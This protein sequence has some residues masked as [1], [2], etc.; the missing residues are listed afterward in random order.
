MANKTYRYLSP[1]SNYF[2]EVIARELDRISLLNIDNKH[3][4]I[5]SKDPLKPTYV[6]LEKD[7]TASQV[8]NVFIT[9]KRAPKSRKNNNFEPDLEKLL[10]DLEA[11]RI[12]NKI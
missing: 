11:C 1:I 4:I 2:P 9:T 10:N 8:T 7:N 6:T 12:P 5:D 3:F